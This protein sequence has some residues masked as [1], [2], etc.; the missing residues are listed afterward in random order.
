M[1]NTPALWYLWGE[2]TV[3]TSNFAKAGSKNKYKSEENEGR[4]TQ[5]DADFNRP[6][7][8]PSFSLKMRKWNSRASI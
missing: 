6:D 5:L 7:L 8:S 3:F 2:K 1:V 4:K